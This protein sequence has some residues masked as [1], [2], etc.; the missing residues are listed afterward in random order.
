MSSSRATVNRQLRS[1]SISWFLIACASTPSFAADRAVKDVPLKTLRAGAYAMDITPTEFPISSAGSMTPRLA[2]QAHDPLYARCLVLDNGTT[3]IALVTCDSCMIPRSIYDAA[4]EH[5]AKATG[6]PTNHLL[7]SATH[8]HT[9][10]TVTD[11]FQSETDERYVEFLTERITECIIRAH[12]QLESAQIGWAIGE[13]PRQVFNRRWFMRPGTP[14]DDPFDHGTDRVRMNPPPAGDSL[15]KPAGDI[16]PQVPVL[17]VK[18]ID[19]RPIAVWANYS[20]HYV[21]GVPAASLSADYF[22][23]FARQFT[24]LINASE[25]K[26]PFVACMTNGTSGDIN[27]INFFKGNASQPPFE[28]IRL[29]ASDIATSAR[30]AYQ[31]IEY[32][33]WVPIEMRETEIELDVR[34]PNGQE[35]ARAKQ[36]IEQAGPGPWSDRRLIYAGETLDMAKFPATVAVKLQAIRIGDLGIVSS[37]CETF[38]ETGLVIKKHSPLQPTFVIELAN[39]YNGYLPTPKQHTF[40]GYE[41]WRAKSSY[42]APDSE[43]KICK[44]L[45]NLLTLVSDESSQVSAIILDDHFNRSEADDAQEQVGNGWSTNSKSRAKGVKQVDLVDGAMH[46]TKASVAD[47]GVSVTHEVAFEDAIIEFRFKLG[48][49]D[50]LGINI[51]DMNEKLVHAGHICLARIRPNRIEITDLKTGRM[52]LEMRERRLAEQATKED[53]AQLAAKSKYFD[54]DLATDA[55]HTL[56]VTLA[57]E[58][59]TVEIDDNQ[60]GKFSSAGIGHDTKSRLR[61]AVNRQAWVD[62][63]KVTRTK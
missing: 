38:V 53:K 50:D 10:V 14:I 6:I 21:G 33:K 62:D 35:V 40:G 37:P 1:L 56:K 8:T 22:G 58:T 19:G 15:L 28:Q 36:L 51:A 12:S 55:W 46:I 7:C 24:R 25:T 16:D 41:T 30:D 5:A 23:E 60:I 49:Q 11:V 59:M 13:N 63:V 57:G 48:P 61:L 47:H 26:P 44:T 3:S 18:A 27:N 31:R 2:E 52:N 39:G 9:A 17:S 34:R 20:L 42:L 4:K 29:V 45:L 32:K 54:V 43:P